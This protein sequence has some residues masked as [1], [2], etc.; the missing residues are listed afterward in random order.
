MTRPE[1]GDYVLAT[2]YDDGESWDHW[3]CGWIHSML[4]RY[5]PPRFHVVDNDGEPFRGNGFRRAECIPFH[6]GR[7]LID[8]AKDPL[9]EA[10]GVCVWDIVADLL[11]E[12]IGL[13]FAG[14]RIDGVTY[15]MESMRYNDDTILLKLRSTTGWKQ[16]KK[17]S[18]MEFA[19][20]LVTPEYAA[21][22][23][24]RDFIKATQKAQS[25]LG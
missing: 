7:R 2:K 9:F 24:F 22:L 16:N 12:D 21:S 23:H 3:A 15:W 25:A 8:M 13:P 4:D 14:R 5:D 20:S 18:S 6:I 10:S 1:L 19:Q 17:L 11:K